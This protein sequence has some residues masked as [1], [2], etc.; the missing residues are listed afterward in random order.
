[1]TPRRRPNSNTS[2]NA[3]RSDERRARC[4]RQSEGAQAEHNRSDRGRRRA[5]R[6]TEN[7]RVRQWVADERLRRN[8]GDGKAAT[9]QRCEH[10]T[11]CPQRPDD[12]G[13]R[14]VAR[15]ANRKPK[16]T[17]R[18][19]R[20][21]VSDR[22]LHCAPRDCKGHR[23]HQE[24]DVRGDSKRQRNATRSS[25]SSGHRQPV[26]DARLSS[27]LLD[28]IHVAHPAGANLGKHNAHEPLVLDG[29][30][31]GQGRV[32]RQ[33]RFSLIPILRDT[34]RIADHHDHLG[35]ALDQLLECGRRVS[36]SGRSPKTFTPPAKVMMALT[37][38]AD[39]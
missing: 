39:P 36:A 5:T 14:V 21:H 12:V 24:P 2:S 27:Q 6:N 23:G 10:H 34:E 26:V 15:H 29:G 1:M 4:G 22:D 17:M 31:V 7:V 19:G 33:K 30:D 11:R 38:E 8:P 35:V 25:R 9:D 28:S 16:P 32:G 20:P 18:N 13:E 3:D 37:A